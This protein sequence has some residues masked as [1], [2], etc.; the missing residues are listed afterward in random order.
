MAVWKWVIQA[1]LSDGQLSSP[2]PAIMPRNWKTRAHGILL[3][4]C[5]V[6]VVSFCWACLWIILITLTEVG[7]PVYCACHHSLAGILH[8]IN[9]EREL[10]LGMCLSALLL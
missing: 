10:S 9:R 8:C 1:R 4:L 3:C 7:G 2:H 6:S 5:L